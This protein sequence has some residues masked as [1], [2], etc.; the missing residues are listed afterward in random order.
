MNQRV[1]KGYRAGETTAAELYFLEK[2]RWL[3][4]CDLSY[5]YDHQI[6]I[7]SQVSRSKNI[8]GVLD[9]FCRIAGVSKDSLHWFAVAERDTKGTGRWHHHMCIGHSG[10]ETT[11]SYQRNLLCDCW[12][13][14]YRSKWYENWQER[15]R[16]EPNQKRNRVLRE[17]YEFFRDDQ[18]AYLGKDGKSPIAFNILGENTFGGGEKS[19]SPFNGMGQALVQLYDKDKFWNT[20]VGYRCKRPVDPETGKPLVDW[21]HPVFVDL[22]PKLFRYWKTKQQYVIPEIDYR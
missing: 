11:S 3:L 13:H 20:G 6:N 15:T 1:T 21:Q 4:T 14:L 10:L 19:K 2:S 5:W 18:V 12:Q 8:H 22:S 7:E 16:L 9:I 17:R